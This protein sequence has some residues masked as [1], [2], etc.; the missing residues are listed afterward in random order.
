MKL[1]KKHEKILK[2]CGN[3]YGLSLLGKIYNED[4]DSGACRKEISTQ[5]DVVTCFPVSEEVPITKKAKNTFSCTN[6]NLKDA[7]ISAIDLKL[8]MNSEVQTKSQCDELM[9]CYDRVPPPSLGDASVTGN[10]VKV[11]SIHKIKL[12]EVDKKTNEHAT[13]APNWIHK[14]TKEC[15]MTTLIK[16]VLDPEAKIPSSTKAT[17]REYI[18]KKKKNS[19][20]LRQ[21]LI[22]E[23]ALLSPSFKVSTQSQTDRRLMRFVREKWLEKDFK[24]YQL[25]H[26]KKYNVT[27]ASSATD[28]NIEV[29]PS[30][31]LK[32]L[33]RCSSDPSYCSG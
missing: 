20:K 4:S 17:S 21:D 6:L 13:A 2:N 19:S 23:I 12:T 33:Y 30:D 27:R 25:F 7:N 29:N 32:T 18:M 24:V 11:H 8:V 3:I 26:S 22:K 5:W 10:V 9:I 14:I 28:S 16:R 31:E 15:S 1:R